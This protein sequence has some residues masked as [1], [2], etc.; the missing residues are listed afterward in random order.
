MLVLTRRNGEQLQIVTDNNEVIEIKITN[1]HGHQVQIGFEAPKSCR[2]LR[3]ELINK[4][5]LVTE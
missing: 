2:I 4:E 5:A 1:I 3:E